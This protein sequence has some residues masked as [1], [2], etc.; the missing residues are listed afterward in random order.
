MAECFSN[1]V[2]ADRLHVRLLVVP[3]FTSVGTVDVR[4]PPGAT[5]ASVR[6]CSSRSSTEYLH[7]ANAAEQAVLRADGLHAALESLP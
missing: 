7:A 3:P 4:S 5:V 1:N 2:C 6:T